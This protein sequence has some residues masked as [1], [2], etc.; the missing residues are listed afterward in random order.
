MEPERERVAAFEP[1]R[2][3]LPQLRYAAD[4][5]IFAEQGGTLSDD[6]GGEGGK[7]MP[8]FADGHVDGR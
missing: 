1:G 8:W 5:R 6:P 7:A 2:N 4:G 3:R